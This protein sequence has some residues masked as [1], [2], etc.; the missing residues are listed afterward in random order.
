MLKKYT[1]SAESHAADGAAR[2]PNTSWPPYFQLNW[3]LSGSLQVQKQFHAQFNGAG[4]L[5]AAGRGRER[6]R[7]LHHDPTLK[8]LM[9]DRSPTRSP[10]GCRTLTRRS[11][12]ATRHR[13]LPRTRRFAAAVAASHVVFCNAAAFSRALPL[14]FSWRLLKKQ[15]QF[16][17][18]LGIGIGASIAELAGA[19]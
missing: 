19:H 7:C 1:S 8:K 10:S 12:D 6:G 15:T 5:A 4:A 18:S 16:V 2:P 13:A 3:A 9:C 17:G 11:C 14:S